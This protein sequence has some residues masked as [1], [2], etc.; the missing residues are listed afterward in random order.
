[1]S[2]DWSPNVVQY[3][4]AN[5][6]ISRGNGATCLICGGICNEQLIESFLYRIVDYGGLLFDHPIFVC[7]CVCAFLCRIYH[8]NIADLS[9]RFMLQNGAKIFP[10]L[11]LQAFIL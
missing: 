3:S 5:V 4:K 8:E 1:V 11:K 10:L 2:K 9:G 6:N 7:V